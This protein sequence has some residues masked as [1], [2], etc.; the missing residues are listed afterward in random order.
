MKKLL[1]IVI[2]LIAA[3][4]EPIKKVNKNHKTVHENVV[5]YPSDVFLK[6]RLASTEGQTTIGMIQTYSQAIDKIKIQLEKDVNQLTLK[7]NDKDSFLFLRNHENWKKLM[8]SDSKFLND[9][10]ENDSTE[11]KLFGRETKI[12]Q[13]QW[14]YELYKARVRFVKEMSNEF[15]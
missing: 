9:V 1:F 15:S 11:N 3:C 13:L 4:K 6:N 14:M 7:L 10:F 8:K 12:H 5:Q 2:L